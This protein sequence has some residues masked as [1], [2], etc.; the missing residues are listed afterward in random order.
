[1]FLD[2]QEIK[3][4][5]S[6]ESTKNP[7]NSSERLPVCFWSPC[8]MKGHNV[9]VANFKKMLDRLVLSKNVKSGNPWIVLLAIPYWKI[10]SSG[11]SRKYS[12]SRSGSGFKLFWGHW[13]NC[14]TIIY[15]FCKRQFTQRTGQICKQ[16]EALPIT[17]T[18]GAASSYVHITYL[19]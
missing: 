12:Y 2:L 6:L 18:Q 7:S 17:S 1:M 16:L 10:N 8:P 11:F 14:P 19:T 5:S 13:R 15:L 3:S 4:T 9:F